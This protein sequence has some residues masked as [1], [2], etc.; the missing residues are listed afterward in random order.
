MEIPTLK[1]DHC[2]TSETDIILKINDQI[3]YFK[4]FSEVHK[5]RHYYEHTCTY[6]MSVV[7]M[8]SIIKCECLF[9]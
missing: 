5:L 2:E 9:M 6:I 8:I 7:L 4:P 1:T 3:G